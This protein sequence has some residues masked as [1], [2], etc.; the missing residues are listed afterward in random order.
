MATVE[1]AHADEG[2]ATNAGAPKDGPVLTMMSKR[3]RALRKKYNKILQIEESK[4]QGKVINKE[5]EDV[6]RTK[7]A[8]AVLID[9]YEKLRQPLLVAVKEELAER[10]RELMSADFGRREPE[11]D[12]FENDK[13]TEPKDEVRKEVVNGNANHVQDNPE[14]IV[15]CF[16]NAALEYSETQVLDSDSQYQT[17]DFRRDAD[18]A[19]LRNDI[20]K[21]SIMRVYSEETSANGGLS[22]AQVADLL[23]LLYFARLFDVKPEEEL[24]SSVW[25]KVHERSSCLSYDFVFDDATTPLTE[26]DLDALSFFGSL[27]TSRPPNVT[28]SHKDALEQC[29]HHARLWLLNSDSRIYPELDASY[30]NL[31]E[32]LNRIMSSEY[33]T[34]TPELQTVTQQTAAAAAS[35]ASHYV[36]KILIPEAMSGPQ[37]SEVGESSVHEA[38]QASSQPQDFE[39]EYVSMIPLSAGNELPVADPIVNTSCASEDSSVPADYPQHSIKRA[40]E[41][42]TALSPHS[43]SDQETE[44]QQEA[45]QPLPPTRQR[46]QHDPPRN[47]GGIRGGGYQGARGNGRGYGYGNGGRGRGYANGRGNRGGRGSYGRG[48]QFYEQDGYYPRNQYGGR[49]GRGGRGGFANDHVNGTPT[50]AVTGQ[51]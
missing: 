32:R 11:E 20:E 37:V 45:L 22:E 36:S 21:E 4:A 33:L 14:H 1:V 10:E 48:G 26:G 47:G 5:Q 30:T 51:A 23:N 41:V 13:E 35:A 43:T 50:A 12:R 44:V 2:Y 28:L 40:D 25:T 9:E 19:S 7:I 27:L 6:L 17:D 34:M 15:N 38:H 46:Q 24:P 39:G 8:I 31:R 49:S 16:S 3:L 18:K 42:Q 29:I